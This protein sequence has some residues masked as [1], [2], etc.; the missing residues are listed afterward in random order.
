MGLKTGGMAGVWTSEAHRKKGYASQVMWASIEEM[1]RRGYHA[2]ILYGIE[3]FYNRYSYSVCF[4]SP[5]CQVAAE[6]FSVPVPGFRV[7][8][9]KKGYMPRI[10]GLYQRYNEGRSASAI[11]A[12]RWMPNCR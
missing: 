2:S 7:R 4:A 8:T 6:S 11:R 9:A 3:D 1:D 10:S 12:R 5:I